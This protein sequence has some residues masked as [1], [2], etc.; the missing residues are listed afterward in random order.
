MSEEETVTFNL[1]LN[2]EKTF[3]EFRKLELLMYRTFALL[4]RFG[5]PD[6]ISRGF[7]LIQRAI[8]SIR[9]LQTALIALD[10]ASGP[11]GWAL[12]IVG[13]GS[14]AMTLADTVEIGMNTH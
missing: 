4:R 10:A 11:V 8:L 5:L 12:A 3:S 9:M 1:E 13:I 2:V 14:A 7:Y 6:D